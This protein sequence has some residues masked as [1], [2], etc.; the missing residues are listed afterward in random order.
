V[1]A[2]IGFKFKSKKLKFKRLIWGIR[3]CENEGLMCKCV[4][5]QMVKY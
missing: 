3:E 4:D 5:V 2:K 1:G